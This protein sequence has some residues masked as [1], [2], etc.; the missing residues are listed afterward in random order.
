MFD[1]SDILLV[2]GAGVI[3]SIIALNT[4]KMMINQEQTQIDAELLYSGVAK[5]QEYIDRART[6]AFDETTVMGSTPTN[7][8]NGFTHPS[9]LGTADDNDNLDDDGDDVVFDDFD[10]FN[11][12]NRTDTT[13]NCVYN[14]SAEVHYVD[15]NNPTAVAGGRTFYKCM[16]VTVTSP[17]L[18]DTIRL[19]Y[20]K[21]FF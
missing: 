6:L 11:G 5:A 10:D 3:F 9:H 12:M 8:P 2:L 13:Q 4:N 17:F 7:L 1:T 16:T 18:A 15:E 21:S 19:Q 20:V 14:I